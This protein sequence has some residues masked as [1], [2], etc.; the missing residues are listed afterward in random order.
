MRAWRAASRRADARTTLSLVLDNASIHRGRSVEDAVK[1][2][3]G[4]RVELE[5]LPPYAPTLNPIELVNA[6]LKSALK[7]DADVQEVKTSVD[8]ESPATTTTLKSLIERTID[9]RLM[10]ASMRAKY[11]HCGWRQK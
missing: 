11:G 10:G 5:Y 3:G 4:G 1:R 7:S 6:E 9:E 2:A 8:G